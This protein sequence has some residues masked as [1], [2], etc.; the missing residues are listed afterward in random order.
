[1]A[2]YAQLDNNNIV[3]NVIYGKDESLDE[4]WELF[5]TNETGIVHKRTSYNTYGNQHIAGGI[6][7]RKNFAGI[8]YSYD[9]DRDAFIPPKPFKSW[10]LNETTCLWEPPFQPPNNYQLYHWDDNLNNW[11]GVNNG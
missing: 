7:F 5:Y 1:M 9:S 6:P 3:I 4:Y 8:G 2:H 11:V 10:I